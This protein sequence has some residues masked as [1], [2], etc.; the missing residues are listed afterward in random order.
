MK[1]FAFQDDYEKKDFCTIESRNFY[2]FIPL[3]Q[4]GRFDL[5]A[6]TFERL[7]LKEVELNK[8]IMR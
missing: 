5:P 3:E 4:Y 2:E 1:V 6:T 7:T 8:K